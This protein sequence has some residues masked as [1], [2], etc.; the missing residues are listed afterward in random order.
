MEPE[1]TVILGILVALIGLMGTL[2]VLTMRKKPSIPP[3][4]TV[5]LQCQSHPSIESAVQNLR[6]DITHL[7]ISNNGFSSKLDGLSSHMTS[8]EGKIDNLNDKLDLA[9]AEL[10]RRF[11]R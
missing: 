3:A 9:K 10:E 8:V 4:Q 6:S 1:L 11:E 2:I 5:T 7:Q